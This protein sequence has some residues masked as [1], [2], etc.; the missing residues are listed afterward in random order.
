MSECDDDKAALRRQGAERPL[1]ET[2]AL[3]NGGGARKPQR[4]VVLE[5]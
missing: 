5:V 4:R 1:R 3:V 2:I